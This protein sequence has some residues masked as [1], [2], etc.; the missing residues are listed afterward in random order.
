MLYPA[1]LLMFLV[2][3]F[4]ALY[5]VGLAFIWEDGWRDK[6]LEATK[7]L[8]AGPAVCAGAMLMVLLLGVSA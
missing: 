6:L 5:E 4:F 8:G 3:S 2:S 1:A 7:A